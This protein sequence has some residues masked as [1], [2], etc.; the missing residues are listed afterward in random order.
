VTV[1]GIQLLG[2][3][4]TEKIIFKLI[5]GLTDQP[6]DG[7]TKL[8]FF[9]ARINRLTSEAPEGQGPGAAQW[10]AYWPTPLEEEAPAGGGG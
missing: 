8:L 4:I 3:Q 6:T 10:Q 2:P 1:I 5:W 9:V 7:R